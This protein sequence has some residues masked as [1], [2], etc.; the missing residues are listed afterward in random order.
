M[1][2]SVGIDETMDDIIENTY[3]S[4][5]NT[6]ESERDHENNV[7]ARTN[8]NKKSSI[9]NNNGSAANISNSEAS[10]NNI[11]VGVVNHQEMDEQAILTIV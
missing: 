2:K 3:G 6:N 10:Q 7:T 5:L 4:R 9:K 11:N 8:E 1:I